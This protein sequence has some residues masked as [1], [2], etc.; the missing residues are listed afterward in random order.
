MKV[1]LRPGDAVLPFAV[2]ALAGFEP[3]S[4]CF[5]KGERLPALCRLDAAAEHLFQLFRVR[6]LL[7]QM[8]GVATRERPVL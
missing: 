7:Q 5:V 1:P 6:H 3:V 4:A 8:M 2:I